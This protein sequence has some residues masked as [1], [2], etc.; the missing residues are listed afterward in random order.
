MLSEFGFRAVYEAKAKNL[1]NWLVANGVE[2]AAACDIVQETFLRL[3][4]QR[5]EFADGDSPNAF[6][7][8]VARNLRIDA[9][10][11]NSRYV[12]QP[13]ITEPD[14]DAACPRALES[15]PAFLRERLLNA[16]FLLPESLR[17]AY[18][19]FQIGGNSIRDITAITGAGESLVKVRI[20]R[21]RKRLRE[22]LA[23]LR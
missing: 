2:Y 3:W 18:T 14:A 1:T 15:D 11:R 4:R 21:A 6:I 19:L 12:F 22:L 8:A 20:H 10:R 23:D 7:F 16:L 9:Y 13:E 5:A 17:T